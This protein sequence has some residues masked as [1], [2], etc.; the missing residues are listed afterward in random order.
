VDVEGERRLFTGGV[1]EIKADIAA[2]QELGVSS[3]LFRFTRATMSET[4]DAQSS[5]ADTFI[6][7]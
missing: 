2:L 3:L 4:E 7:T 6:A 5:F 1:D